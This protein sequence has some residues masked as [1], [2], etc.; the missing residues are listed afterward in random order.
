MSDDAGS[1]RSSAYIAERN[2][3]HVE[4]SICR[5]S[6]YKKT[7]SHCLKFMLTFWLVFYIY[8]CFAAIDLYPL[9]ST[10]WLVALTF[11]I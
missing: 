10:H 3:K 5:K 11:I 2:D 8:T 7:V 6:V 1:P 4:G 9:Q